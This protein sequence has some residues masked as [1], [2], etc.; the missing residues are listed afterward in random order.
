MG[1]RLVL[2]AVEAAVRATGVASAILLRSE[3][4]YQIG[5]DGNVNSPLSAYWEL[6]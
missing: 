3:R 2:A 5:Q 6:Y 4:L 1:F